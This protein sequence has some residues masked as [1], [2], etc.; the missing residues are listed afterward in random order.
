MSVRATQQPL[1]VFVSYSHDDEALRT[2][3]VKH[4]AQLQREGSID[5]WHD[6]LIAGGREWA[7][8]IDAQL[9]AADIILLLLSA[10]FLASDYCS[11]V[12]MTRAL[13]RHR[14][15]EARVVPVIL[16]PC[17]W[18]TAAFGK[19]QVLPRDGQPVIEWQPVDSG[20]LEVA[21]GL[22][23][24]IAELRGQ[25]KPNAPARM[26]SEDAVPSD[27][28]NLRSVIPQES[29]NVVRT[30]RKLLWRLTGATLSV[31]L[32]VALS[33][34]VA[35]WRSSEPPVQVEWVRLDHH[36]VEE[37][38]DVSANARPVESKNADTR[39]QASRAIVSLDSDLVKDAE[40]RLGGWPSWVNVNRA[41][42]S[43]PEPL[44]D[45]LYWFAS[46][47][48]TGE[49]PLSEIRIQFSDDPDV[50]IRDLQPG[51][52]AWIPIEM[53]GRHANLTR[54][55][56]RIIQKIRATLPASWWGARES[57]VPL[58]SRDVA[59]RPSNIRGVSYGYPRM[60]SGMGS[61]QRPVGASEK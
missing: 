31:L 45:Q 57:L 58:P 28:T 8:V 44:R 50:V 59:F 46:V 12:E 11:D 38:L 54:T 39:L 26:L 49:S 53:R 52:L 4:L 48:N 51:V 42:R 13:E 61:A 40:G 37:L 1:K 47:K 41:A 36:G 27:S 25:S 30:R 19:L 21:R 16:R 56:R 9:D 43:D 35:R 20:Y 2:Q 5:T 60:A 32:L 55:Q 14:T 17:D 29:F 7:G 15:G 6:R 10:S 34:E 22:R 18:H 3:L 23:R 33:L 24:I